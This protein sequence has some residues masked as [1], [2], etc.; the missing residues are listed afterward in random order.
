M[1]VHKRHTKYTTQKS[2]GV[3]LQSLIALFLVI[4]ALCKWHGYVLFNVLHAIDLN[5]HYLNL[6]L[7]EPDSVVSWFDCEV[8]GS[9]PGRVI[10]N[11]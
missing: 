9:N 11:P 10:P 3:G 7:H 2:P 8:D 1:P 5:C 4:F 6:K